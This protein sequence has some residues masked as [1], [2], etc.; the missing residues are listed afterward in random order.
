[1]CGDEAHGLEEEYLSLEVLLGMQSIDVYV[2]RRQLAWL[3]HVSR[4]GYERIPRK[5][6][7]SWVDHKRTKGGVEMTYGRGMNK[8][9]KRAG[10]VGDG[11]SWHVRAQDRPGWAAMIKSLC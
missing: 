1:M 11:E 6:L 10:L 8:A 2:Y 5:L 7:S 3:G 9:F 4:M